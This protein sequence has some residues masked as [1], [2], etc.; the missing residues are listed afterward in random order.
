MKS[1]SSP[2]SPLLRTVRRLKLRAPQSED[3]FLLEGVKL[4]REAM[5]AR[6]PVEQALVSTGLADSSE[7][8]RLLEELDRERIRW[9]TVAE[10]LFRKLTSLETPEGILL[11]A[12]KAQQPLSAVAGDI[13]VV[14]AGVQDPGNVGAVAR[15]AEAAGASGLVVCE[16]TADPFQAKAMRGAMGSL[17]RLGV[18]KGGLPETALSALKQ[19]GFQAA[20][21]VPRGGTR[22]DRAKFRFPFAL[23]LGS[24]SQGLPESLTEKVDD[25]LSVPMRPPVESLNVAVAAGLL[26][27]E[28]ARQRGSFSP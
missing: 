14:C 23:F 6:I 15:V 16:G 20:A 21:C 1:I 19:K 24:E 12:R 18:F 2:A 28:V 8:R 17:L 7:G 11:I 3:R 25:R 27:Y 5:S 13:V 9:V 26:L 22:Y 4:A 10:R